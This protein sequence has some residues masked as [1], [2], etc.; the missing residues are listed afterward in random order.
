MPLLELE[1]ENGPL[2]LQSFENSDYPQAVPRDYEF[3]PAGAVITMLV[4]IG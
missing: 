4:A 1:Y 2:E 3:V